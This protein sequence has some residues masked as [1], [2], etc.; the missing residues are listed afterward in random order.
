MSRSER[1]AYQRLTK[2][3]DPYAPPPATAAARARMERQRARRSPTARRGESTSLLGGRT[4]WVVLGG[5]A[6]A[7]LLGFSLAW[8]NSIGPALLAG[9]G[10][11]LAWLAVTL[12]FVVWRRRAAERPADSR[13]AGPR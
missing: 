9:I 6:A 10:A 12:G 1:R 2:K 11:G 7:F 13:G 4:G 3:Q 5:G 8:P